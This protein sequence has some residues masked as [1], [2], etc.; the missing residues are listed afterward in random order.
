MAE[1]VDVAII[2]GGIMGVS[3]AYWL[4]RFDPGLRI[5]VFERDPMHEFSSTALSVASIRLQFSNPANVRVSRFG[6]EFI[7]E[8]SA[9]TRS[10]GG[11]DLGFRSNGYL[12]LVG[13]EAGAAT[14]AETIAMQ[15]REGAGTMALTAQDLAQRFAW[16][17]TAGVTLASFGGQAEGWFDNMGLLSGL[18]DLARLQGVRFEHAEVTGL[19]CKGRAVETLLLS[20]GRVISVG[21]VVNAAGPRAANVMAMVGEKFPVEPRKRT[22]FVVDAPG[23]RHPDAPLLIDYQG[24]YARPEGNCWITACVPAQDAAVAPDDFVPSHCDFDEIIWPKLYE[25]IPGFDRAKVLRHWV[26]HYAFN[27][28]DQNAILGRHPEWRNLSLINGFSGH[29]L[30]QAPAMGRGLAELLVHGGF[31]SLDLSDFAMERILEKRPFRELG[32]V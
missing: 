16:M 5:C 12:F 23:A 24:Y 15:R 3:T 11:V 31:R 28:L 8:F 7:R 18:R 10:V 32:I 6:L 2:G 19:K 1:R 27:T 22:V 20:S 17:N 9:L 30:Q 4:S 25:R 13:S 29:G 14:L 21:E 26:G